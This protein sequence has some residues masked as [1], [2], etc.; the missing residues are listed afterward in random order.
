MIKEPGRGWWKTLFLLLMEQILQLIPMHWKKLK[1]VLRAVPVLVL[2]RGCH[3][4]WEVIWEQR[5]GD[6]HAA[7][8]QE[9]L[10]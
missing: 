4:A 6:Q 1:S 7:V 10:V 5:D 2:Q 9:K 3:G 8:V